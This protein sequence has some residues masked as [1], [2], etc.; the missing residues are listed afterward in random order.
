MWWKAEMIEI[1]AAI[2]AFT[3]SFLGLGSLWIGKLGG[4]VTV[5]A[6]YLWLA[7][8]V[9]HLRGKHIALLTV[10][11]PALP[12]AALI[13]QFRDSHDSHLASIAIVLCWL[14]GITLGAFAANPARTSYLRLL[15]CIAGMSVLHAVVTVTLILFSFGSAM[16]RFDGKPVSAETTAIDAI[17]DILVQPLMSIIG[18]G[19]VRLSPLMQWLALGANS[20]TWGVLL[21]VLLACALRF[22]HRDAV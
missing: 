11:L 15:A 4:E 17:T 14:A 16:Q 9:G 18:D 21:G 22:G 10:A 20:L 19:S 2:A 12:I 6:L 13:V 5:A 8:S 7:Y 1:P 3:L